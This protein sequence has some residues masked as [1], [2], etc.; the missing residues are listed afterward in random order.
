VQ[1]K[2]PR[3][4]C[5]AQK[6]AVFYLAQH[7]FRPRQLRLFF[8]DDVPPGVTGPMFTVIHGFT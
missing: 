5:L 3:G 8:V 7:Q 1:Q 4:L 6:R 2:T